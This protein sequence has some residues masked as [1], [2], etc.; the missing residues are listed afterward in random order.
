MDLSRRSG[1]L[2]WTLCVPWWDA[3]DS[4]AILEYCTYLSGMPLVFRLWAFTSDGSGGPF[5][6]GLRVVGP[7][8]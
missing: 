7:V 8:W 6:L 1:G 4:S 5:I 2:P 3:F